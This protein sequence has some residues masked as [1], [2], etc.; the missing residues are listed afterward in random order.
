MLTAEPSP[1]LAGRYRVESTLA[2]GGVAVVYAA[3]DMRLRRPVTVKMLRT[4]RAADP[5]LR[6]RFEIE[7]RTVASLSHPNVVAIH[8]RGDDAGV[9]F[10]VMERL[11]G[12]TLADEIRA[13]Q[14]SET[15]VIE[16]GRQVLAALAVAHAAGIVHGDVRPGNI[17]T[18]EGG[19]VKVADFGIS[20]VATTDPVASSGGVLLGALAYL[21]PERLDDPPL[22]PAA[23]IYS[24]GAVLYECLVGQPVFEG[25]SPAALVASIRHGRPKPIRAL[26]P[27]C[28]QGLVTV[29]ERALDPNPDQRFASAAAMSGALLAGSAPSGPIALPAAPMVPPEASGDS[30]AHPEVLGT[31]LSPIAPDGDLLPSPRGTSLP[32]VRARMALSPIDPPAADRLPAVAQAAMPTFRPR[33]RANR[34]LVAIVAAAM[35]LG[36]LIGGGI[37][38]AVK[39]ATRPSASAPAVAGPPST[40]SSSFLASFVPVPG[41]LHHVA[42]ALPGKGHSPASPRH[43]PAKHHTGS[44]RSKAH[45]AK[46]HKASRPAKHHPAQHR[47]KS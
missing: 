5:E 4:E 11:P 10:L 22:A 8:D 26:R 3:T 7:A 16:V 42:V 28:H 19:S 41:A 14:M 38:L 13:G 29:I 27:D 30:P 47:R 25:E 39:V 32:V 2:R 45:R 18:C 21:P 6:D 44:D 37:V 24:V 15:R 9:G 23:D 33:V 35:L 17:L 1:L 43:H 12:T 31:A 20:T 34:R 46:R 36:A 40:G